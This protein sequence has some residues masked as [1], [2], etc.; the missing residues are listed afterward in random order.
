[1]NM[2]D[3]SFLLILTFNLFSTI[4]KVSFWTSC[5]DKNEYQQLKIR[6]EITKNPAHMHFKNIII[7]KQFNNFVVSV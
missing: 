2:L 3:I 4:F 1:M 5:N 7:L 6:E